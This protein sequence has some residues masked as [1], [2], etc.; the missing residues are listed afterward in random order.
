MSNYLALL[1]YNLTSV[2]ASTINY[3]TLIGS[4]IIASSIVSNS[5]INVSSITVQNINYSTLTGSTL[6]AQAVN[7]SMLTGSTMTNNTL[8][9]NST[10][11]GST[12]TAQIINYS[13]LTGSTMT[14]NTLVVNST[15]SGS[16]I[17]AQIINYSTLTGSTMTNN[18]LTINSTLSGS[19]IT[20]RAINYSTL[21]GSTMTNNTLTI[22]STLNVSSIT[23]QTINYSTLIGS[24]MTI[25]TL[26]IASTLTVS[27]L[28]ATNNPA[29]VITSS[30]ISV[31]AS[32]NQ[33]YTALA[34]GN[35]STSTNWLSTLNNLSSTKFV[36]MSGNA[37]TQLAITQVATVSSVY[38]TSTIGTSWSTI[39]NVTGLPTATQTNYSC[40]A[41]S[42]NGQYAVLGT[43]NGYL[44]LT[45][46][47]TS[48]T[49]PS[50]T[51]VNPIVNSNTPV[52]YLPLDTV[53][54]NGSTS[55]G[56]IPATLTVTGTITSVP[57]IVGTNAI[58]LA[59]T[60][61]GIPVNYLRGNVA[62]YTNFT[63]SGWFNLQTL[64]SSSFLSIIF[65]MGTSGGTFFDIRYLGGTGL[66]VNY[67]NTSN[68][69][70][71]IATAP[72]SA[73]IWYN[74]TVIFQSG[75]TSYVYLNNVLIGTATT[76]ALLYATTT[77]AL[78]TYANTA[79]DAFNG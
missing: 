6:T 74:F 2:N 26:V 44:Y 27:T 70:I 29:G 63:V 3:S 15:L 60:A 34:Q 36:A 13:T 56:S 75:S 50:F 31:G 24:T 39:S 51:N 40:G 28:I 7:Y 22:N 79:V 61:A 1:N 69:A 76:T 21:T 19:T 45:N 58:R 71:T 47:L 9:V 33:S 16:T 42:G 32:T 10:L 5:S 65:G 30:M 73:N 38:Y 77:F 35:Y 46:T 59:N 20:A 18:T 49:G 41:V 25:N 62:N 48:A 55:Q 14:N 23:S 54:G 12:I 68:T 4:T 57:G 53:P 67:Y 8:V 17:T 52:V 37:Q 78:G 64:P 11:S 72:V 43:T 66:V